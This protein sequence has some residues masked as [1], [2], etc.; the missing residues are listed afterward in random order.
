M[1]KQTNRV[2]L[3]WVA[4]VVV[5]LLAA[6]SANRLPVV[7]LYEQGSVSGVEKQLRRIAGKW[8]GVPYRYGGQGRRGIDCSALVAKIYDATFH[9]QLPR[10][11]RKQMK[12]GRPVGNQPLAAGDIVFFNTGV[13]GVHSGIYLGRGEFVHA[14]S[15]KGV[16]V[17]NINNRY[18]LRHYLA[19][20]RVIASD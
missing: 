10:T 7:H 12:V 15:R 3:C 11:V 19:A 9:F 18:W 6:C 2:V 17:S 4:A 1:T 20:R 13:F 14:S 5:L 16:T 8:V